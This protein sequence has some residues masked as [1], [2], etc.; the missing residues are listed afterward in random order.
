L[1]HEHPFAPPPLLPARARLSWTDTDQER[2]ERLSVQEQAA[3]GI[4]HRNALDAREDF[5]SK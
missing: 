4:T 5:N 2:S 3:Q 1:H